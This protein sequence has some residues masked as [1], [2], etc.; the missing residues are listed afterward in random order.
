MIKIEKTD[1]FIYVSSQYN[2]QLPSR[3]KMIAGRWDA[4][5]KAWKFDIRDE[6]DVRSLYE[7]L[8]GEYDSPVKKC[9]I[10]IRLEKDEEEYAS[11]S[12]LFMYGREICRAYS[13]DSGAKIGKGVKLIGCVAESSG[14]RKNWCSQIRATSDDA[15]IEL[16]DIP[17]T[18]VNTDLDERVLIIDSEE[19]AI[20]DLKKRKEKLLKELE[21]IELEIEKISFRIASDSESLID[22][23]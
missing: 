22:E 1:D 8:Y 5:R 20:E 12:P 17:V 15:Y 18:L 21:E 23:D 14:S 7:E 19:V 9:T 16:K 2:D 3:A 6:D 4:Q 11:A 13:R 10:R